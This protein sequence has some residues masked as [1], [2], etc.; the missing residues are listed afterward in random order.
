MKF[1]AFHL[2]KLNAELVLIL[3]EIRKKNRSEA[4][5]CGGGGGGVW[6]SG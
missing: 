5:L 1:S 4:I 6:L 3:Q 2:Q